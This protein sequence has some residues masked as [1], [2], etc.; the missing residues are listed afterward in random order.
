LLVQNTEYYK[1]LDHATASK[2]LAD[3]KSGAFTSP[4]VLLWHSRNC[5]NSKMAMSTI[6]KYAEDNKM[7]VY[8]IDQYNTLG[9]SVASGSYLFKAVGMAAGGNPMQGLGAAGGSAVFGA[10]TIVY[11]VAFAF[12]G[13]TLQNRQLAVPT[14]DVGNFADYMMELNFKG[15]KNASDD[16]PVVVGKDPVDFTQLKAKWE[17]NKPK[18]T[19]ELY[20]IASDSTHAP[21]VTGEIN[22]GIAEDG[23]AMANFVRY[24]AHLPDD[25]VLDKTLGDNAQIGALIV[26]SMGALSHFPKKNPK[27]DQARYDVGYAAAGSSNLSLGSTD[28]H[29]AVLGYMSDSDVDNIDAVG[30]RRWILNPPLKKTGFG[31][32]TFLT[33]TYGLMQVTDRSRTEDVDY[34]FVS[35]PTSGYQ[36]TETFTKNDAWSVSLNPLKFNAKKTDDIRVKLTAKDGTVTTFSPDDKNKGGKFFAVATENAGIPFAVIFRPMTGYQHGDRYDVEIT[37]V[38]RRGSGK[39]VT[40]K[41]STDF[42]SLEGNVGEQESKITTE[43]PI[44]TQQEL[45][46]KWEQLKPRSTGSEFIQVPS[47]TPPYQMGKLTEEAATDGTNMI[48][49]MRYIVGRDDPVP[50]RA[51]AMDHD[52]QLLAFERSYNSANGKE[53]LETVP[54][55]VTAAVGES[56]RKYWAPSQIRHSG[57]PGETLAEN[58]KQSVL[59]DMEN[60]RRVLVGKFGSMDNPRYAGIGLGHTEQG[61]SCFEMWTS[62]VSADPNGPLMAWP[63]AGNHPTE[64]IKK[65]ASWTLMFDSRVY[66]ATKVSS[67][68]TTVTGPGGTFRPKMLKGPP[69]IELRAGQLH[70]YFYPGA[71]NY[72]PGD[73]YNVK[74]E[75]IYKIGDNMPYTM[76]YTVNFFSL[77]PNAPPAP[78]RSVTLANKYAAIKEGETFQI[79]PTVGPAHADQTVTYTVSDPSL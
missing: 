69:C 22:D 67:Y 70:L 71:I 2:L 78:A 12:D 72:Y 65:G 13:K 47:I 1:N 34:N 3:A 66:D 21:F 18:Y 9:G 27:M 77:D 59:K 63:V 38:Y 75:N 62:G 19:G 4:F 39:P 50:P 79:E 43:I 57:Q 56:I 49:F 40:I 29:S 54:A 45:R 35:W 42:V 37:G 64:F 23:L 53:V 58:L 25:L 15:F 20:R 41:Y 16:S 10:T 73:V 8:A 33:Y 61:E 17:Q 30:H 46:A 5:P 60:R 55:D 52:N 32:S 14:F 6:R 68:K 76:E 31:F 44:R 11:P 51:E 28:A 7:M 74:I 26:G 24:V 36:P 48:Q